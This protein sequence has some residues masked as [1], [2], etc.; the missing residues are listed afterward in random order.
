MP[1][2]RLHLDDTGQWDGEHL[3]E[4]ESIGAALNVFCEW[5]GY[6]DPDGTAY[7][8]PHEGY[9]PLATYQFKRVDLVTEAPVMRKREGV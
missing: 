1:L 6:H 2:F 8:K 4:A 3:V 7:A 9:E 5:T